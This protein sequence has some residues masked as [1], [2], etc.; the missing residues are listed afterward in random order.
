MRGALTAHAALGA[1][2]A[3]GLLGAPFI[4]RH[5]RSRCAQGK[6]DAAR[7]GER[8][9]QPGAVRPEGPLIWFHA[10]SVGES[11]S[12][13]PLIE[14]IRADWPQINF[15][16]TTGTVTSARLLAER[17]PPGA[18]HQYVPV[19]LRGGAGAGALGLGRGAGGAGFGWAAGAV[20]TTAL[21][22]RESE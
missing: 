18:L 2:R 12:V 11:M 17:L 4:R 1:Y 3:V 5:L 9:G 6:E 14:R 8:L 19:D 16:V 22:R 20:D 7:L 13:L 15:L 10:A 21:A